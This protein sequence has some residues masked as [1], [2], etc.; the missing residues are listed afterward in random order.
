MKFPDL[1]FWRRTEEQR[2]IT[3]LPWDVGGQL[4]VKP[5]TTDQALSLVPVFGAVRLLASQI[6]TLPLQTY[7]KVGDSR[8]KIPTGSLFTN[9]SAH[10]TSYAWLHRCVTSLALRG[11]AYGLITARDNMGYPTMIEWLHPDHVQ[12]EDQALSGPG[13][14]SQPIW[15]WM[16]RIV[17]T[18][19]LVHI[20][21]FTVPYR[22]KGLSPIEACAATIST[23]VSAQ[24][25]TADWFNNGAVP[26]GKFKNTQK[27]VSQPE[28]D[29]IKARLTAAI[30]SRK[31][32]VYGAD[33][34]YDPIAVAA[35]EAKFIETMQLNAT[36]IASIYG[37]PPEML[38]GSTGNSLTYSTVEQNSIN[39]VKF[40]LRPWLELLEE[41]FSQL[42]PRPQYVKFNVDALLR[43]D[44]TTRMTAYQTARQIGLN[45]IDELRNLEDWAP[46]PGG[47]GKDYEPL[48][49]QVAAARG[50]D[51]AQ[52]K[53]GDQATGQPPDQ[54]PPDQAQRYAEDDA[55]PKV[56]SSSMG[57]E[58]RTKRRLLTGAEAA[59]RL[60][61]RR[62]DPADPAAMRHFNPNEP[63]I[64]GGPH[65]GE[66]GSGGG[67]S[68][69]LKDA[70]NL[71]G[72]ID[73]AHDEK[74][75]GSAKID[76]DVGGI[77]M[78]LT[79]QG[80]HRTLRLGLGGEDYG[81]RNR[82]E[83][84]PAWDGNPS[85]SP[86][87]DAD[88]K[89]LDAESEALDAEYESASPARQ[90]QIDAQQADIREQLAADDRGF[91]GTAQLDDYGMRRLADL[92]RPALADAVEQ[93]KRQ[94][95]AWDEIEALEAKG[96]PDPARMERLREIARADATDYLTFAQGIVPGSA[97]GDVHFSV[98]LD[99]PSIGPY[100]KLGVQPK[101]APDD[102][103]TGLDWQGRFDAAETKK[104]LKLLGQYA[105]TS[106]SR[107][108]GHDTTP[109]RDELHH[110][111]TKGPGLAKWVESPTP[112]TTLYH[113]LLKYMA[114]GKAK[115][116]TSAWF[117]EVMGFSSGSD[118][119]RVTHGKP[120]RGK[121]VGPG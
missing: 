104:F 113:H 100:V 21:W 37:I 103:G 48:L 68:H 63:R 97:W 14:Y 120:P 2:V 13:S 115:R 67:V 105:S 42:L 66:W 27:T 40:T 24:V 85:K 76:G 39:F 3:G 8:T 74:L 56:W 87:S 64:P 93:D 116:V 54:I 110:Y 70:L 59:V 11:N 75:V 33:W 55:G 119:N 12:V 9:P 79:E 65:G 20:A 47:K 98:E 29:E 112:W 84:I 83:G 89:R 102:W 1:R 51:A 25:Y 118:L 111:W 81:K 38:G 28:S 26:P 60:M 30:R 99:D 88:R 10:G 78:A 34:E 73:L 101:G 108:A 17:P 46:I 92:I 72:R 36:Q 22:V 121:V 106:A 82:D 4:P 49:V 90:E 91:N 57:G 53:Q 52:V 61:A 43:G 62:H 32:L 35:N 86:L 19:D 80:G 7:R 77:R 69:V 15:Y 58:E 41:T 23:G 107:A 117:T 96:N 16:G 95:D 45:N 6:S 114:P 5:V 18:E 94:N 50:I 44:L 71:D 31:P 109:G